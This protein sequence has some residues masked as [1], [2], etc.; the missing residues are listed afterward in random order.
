MVS[1]QLYDIVEGG[2]KGSLPGRAFDGVVMVAILIGTVIGVL[3]TEPN[4]DDWGPSF[5]VIEG[6]LVLLFTA[7]YGLRVWVSPLHPKGL[8][9][10]GVRGR[11]RYCVTP[12]ALIDLIAIIPGLLTLFADTSTEIMLL[13]RCIRLLKLLRFFSAFDTL[14]VVVRNERKP[15][16]AAIVLMLILLVII[17]SVAFLIERDAQPE[18]FGSVPRAMWWGIVTLATVGYGD[19]VPQ[20]ILGRVMGSVVVLLGMGMFALPAGII[21]TGFAEEMRRR[22]F[23]VSWTLVA[24]VPFFESLSATRIAEIV[25]VLEPRSADRGEMIIEAGDAADGMY[26]L[27]EGE[28]EVRLPDGRKV[29]LAAGQFF[30]EIALLSQRSRAATVTAKSFCQLL[31][32]R[33]DHFHRLMGEHQDLAERMHQIAAERGLERPA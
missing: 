16:M 1:R 23:V 24:K 20:T 33:I 11:L 12:M 19:V 13:L 17:S 27:I 6:I 31:K 29:P 4:L 7:E 26:F 21:A 3:A 30:G 22:N 18:A 14:I 2:S 28:V 9:R 10:D 25:T 32:L 5:V 8:Y 15:L